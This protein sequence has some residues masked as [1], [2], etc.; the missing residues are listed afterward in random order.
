[1][2]AARFFGILTAS[3]LVVAPARASTFDDTVADLQ[4]RLLSVH[5]PGMPLPVNSPRT[6]DKSEFRPRPPADE[7]GLRFFRDLQI[8]RSG[9]ASYLVGNGLPVDAVTGSL[10]GT[11]LAVRFG[12]E[13]RKL[14]IYGVLGGGS[15][16]TFRH[17]IP[18][19]DFEPVQV[20]TESAPF[21]FFGI[22][23]EFRLYR[24]AVLAAET[25]WGNVIATHSSER[26]LAPG[27]TDTVRST[28]AALRFTY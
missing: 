24:S 12:A 9:S 14:G 11:L 10:P 28:V 1:M 25:N 3:L 18:R 21:A 15:F 2:S 8:R 5:R 26:V 6:I 13:L 4:M 19:R 27:P 17:L 16:T 20:A 22:G 7:Y 23:L